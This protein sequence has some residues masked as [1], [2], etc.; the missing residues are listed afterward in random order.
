ML[1]ASIGLFVACMPLNSFCVPQGCSGWPGYGVLAMGWLE[2]LALSAVGPFVAFSWYANPCLLAAWA[3]TVL[4]RRSVGLW[5]AG[6][7]ILL[8]LSFLLGHSVIVSESG[9]AD[10]IVAPAPGYWL[11]LSSLCV[12]FFGVVFTPRA[13]RLDAQPIIQADR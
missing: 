3:C 4:R 11:W 2:L 6:I 1:L 9:S 5:F 12:A 10:R 8:S 13:E 7:G